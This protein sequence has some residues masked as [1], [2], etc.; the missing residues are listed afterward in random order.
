MDQL[1]SS[2]FWNIVRGFSLVERCRLQ[3]VSKLWRK[4]LC[5]SPAQWVYWDAVFSE[6]GQQMTERV[7]KQFIPKV[8]P[9]NYSGGLL[10]QVWLL[11]EQR[12]TEARL[13]LSK[14]WLKAF[15]KRKIRY[16]YLSEIARALIIGERMYKCRTC[17]QL[18]HG[19]KVPTSE[20]ECCRKPRLLPFFAHKVSNIL[21]LSS[22]S[23]CSRCLIYGR[24]PRSIYCVFCDK[25]RSSIEK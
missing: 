9:L 19:P 3:Q 13:G 25:W 4:R 6:S 8:R 21:D 24:M 23:V 18:W 20:Q 16:R 15:R 7:M 1:N 14:S 12:Q 17:R 11:R 2:L 22:S 10:A 5:P